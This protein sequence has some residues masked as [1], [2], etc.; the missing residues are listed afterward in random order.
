MMLRVNNLLGIT[1]EMK[2]RDLQFDASNSFQVSRITHDGRIINVSKE[3]FSSQ[4][5]TD[6]VI[7]QLGL[8]LTL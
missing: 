8:A 4:I 1:G 7:F 2:F 3:P 5:H 6:G